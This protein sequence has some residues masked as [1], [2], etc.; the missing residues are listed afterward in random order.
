M[1]PDSEDSAN[2][3]DRR[4]L[5]IPSEAKAQEVRESKC[6][7]NTSRTWRNRGYFKV[8]VYP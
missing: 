2:E 8:T 3:M 1:F 6:H 5:E 4:Q 7:G